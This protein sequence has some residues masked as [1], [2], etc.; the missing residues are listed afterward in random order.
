MFKVE[1]D[2]EL[3]LELIHPSHAEETFAIVQKNKV[4]TII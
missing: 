2:N 3:H 1:I 4:L